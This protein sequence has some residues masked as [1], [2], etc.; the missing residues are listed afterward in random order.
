[1]IDG[2]ATKKKYGYSYNNPG[3]VAYQ[4]HR[5]SPKTVFWKLRE[6]LFGCACISHKPDLS[7][8]PHCDAFVADALP[9]E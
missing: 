6:R 8:N 5:I 3:L 7:A 2:K 9:S 4:R 1:V